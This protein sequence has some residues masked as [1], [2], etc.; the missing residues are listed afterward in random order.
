[1]EI[2][3]TDYEIFKREQKIKILKMKIQRYKLKQNK[4]KKKQLHRLKIGKAAYSCIRIARFPE[5]EPE[6]KICVCDTCRTQ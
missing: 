6:P 3:N 1:M 2:D 4:R 5:P